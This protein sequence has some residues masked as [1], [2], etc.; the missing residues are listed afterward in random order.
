MCWNGWKINFNIYAIIIFWDMV[1]F[2]LKID[3]FRWIFSAKST[4]TRKIYISEKSDFHSIQL[5]GHLSWKLELFWGW[6]GG[7]AYPWLGKIR[8]I[9]SL[10]I[11]GYQL[12]TLLKVFNAIDSHMS[13]G[14]TFRRRRLG[15]GQLGA[16]PF[17]R[18][19]LRRRFLI[20]FSSYEEKTMNKNL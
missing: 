14:G 18:R 13:G 8:E 17:R 20:Y 11:R 6:E 7:S 10:S 5:C 1:I 3:N 2:I 19:T 9:V 15:A 12:S 4:I 16:V